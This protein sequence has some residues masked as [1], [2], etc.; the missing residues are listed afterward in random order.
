MLLE[1]ALGRV[2]V[3][4]HS[5]DEDMKLALGRGHLRLERTML[6]AQ[7]SREEGCAY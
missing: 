4:D 6:N 7:V 5:V 3:L 1:R 2:I